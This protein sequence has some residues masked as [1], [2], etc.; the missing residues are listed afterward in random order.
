M[1][2]FSE[3]DTSLNRISSKSLA[4]GIN[5]RGSIR[6][7]LNLYVFRSKSIIFLF[8][9]MDYS[10]IIITTKQNISHD[11]F[12][13]ISYAEI[14]NDTNTTSNTINTYTTK[15]YISWVNLSNTK[16]INLYSIE[17]KLLIK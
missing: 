15:N 12:T 3:F 1:K 9:L 6:I 16:D 13:L 17:K 8:N 11:T 10:K 4:L 14:T 7:S 5:L 2:A